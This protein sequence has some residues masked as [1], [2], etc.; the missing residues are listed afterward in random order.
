ME[1][2]RDWQGA[3]RAIERTFVARDWDEAFVALNL[4]VKPAFDAVFLAG[5]S[6]LA[7]RHDDEVDALLLENLLA[8]SQRSARWSRALARFAI[9]Q[10]PVNRAAL[11]LHLAAWRP[12][13][14]EL[15]AGG[16]TLLARF[17]SV[18]AVARGALDALAAEA[19]VG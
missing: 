5:L 4:V 16:S 6:A 14:D 7:R 17:G 19:G 8:D 1:Q 10:R 3:R 2:D 18:G 13:G 15:I 12:L 11:R 9:D